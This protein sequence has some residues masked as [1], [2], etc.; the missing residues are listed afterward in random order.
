MPLGE[1]ISFERQ[2]NKGT[3]HKIVI[4]LLLIIVWRE[5]VRK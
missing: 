1:V 5:N 4:L 3:P 2:N